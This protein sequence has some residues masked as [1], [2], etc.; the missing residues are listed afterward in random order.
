MLTHQTTPKLSGPRKFLPIAILLLAFALRVIAIDHIPPGLSHDEAYNGVTAMQVLDGQRLIFFEINKG[1]EPLIIYLEALAFYAFGIG[2][3]PMRLVN[4]MCGMLTVALIYPLTLRLFKRRV[5]LLAMAG[6]A[7][8]FWA[9]FTSRLALRAVTLPPL[10]M[11]SLYFLWRGISSQK[12]EASNQTS[13]HYSPFA[14]PHPSSPILYPLSSTF[15]SPSSLFFV[16]GGLALGATMYTYLSSRFVPLLVLAIFGYQFLRGQVTKWHWLGLIILLLIWAVIFAPLA[17]Y[18]WQHSA[19]F[20]E[21][22][23]QVSTLPYVLNGDVGP[24]QRHTLRTLGMFTFHGDETDRYNLDG[25]PVFDW[26][27]GLFFYLGLILALLRLRRPAYIA[28]PAALLLLWLFFMLLPGFITD[29]SPHFLRTVGAMPA[30]YILW[31]LGLDWAGQR[32]SRSLRL[33]PHASVRSLPLGRFRAKGPLVAFQSSIL[34]LLTPIFILLLLTGYDY[35]IRWA[36]APEARAIYGADIAEVARYV[37]ATPQEGLVAISAEY[38]RDLDPFRFTL[39][40]YGRPPFVIWFDG[41]QSLAFPPPE[42]GL[43]PRYIFPLSAPPAETWLPFLQS[44]PAQSGREYTLYR[45][46]KVAE[47]HQAQA[48]AFSTPHSLGVNINNDLMLSA[49]Q[50]LGSVVSGGKFRV[51]LGW[52][53]LRTLPPNADY[54]FLVQLQDKEDRVWA[55]ADGNGYPPSEWQ[56]GVQGLQLLV[57]RLPGDLP[58]RAYHLT[59]QV[60]DRHSGQALP[61]SMG[62]TVIPLGNLAGQLAKTPRLIDPAKLPN[63]I[64][65]ASAEGPGQEIALRGYEV[66]NSTAHPGESLAV[67]L[68][69]QVLQPPQNYHLEFSL[70]NDGKETVYRWPAVEPINGE[71]PT[72]Y[73]PAGYWVQDRLDL[74]LG[75]DA[76]V[77]QFILQGAWVSGASDSPQPANPGEIPGSFELGSVTIV[78]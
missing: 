8:S 75:E 38:Y 16:L 70:V 69:W 42:S 55:A 6:L 57:L 9:V 5:A 25:R 30:A 54:T 15:H 67:T 40:S 28:G 62:E 60:V 31:A 48:A 45:L 41:R 52:Q 22:S 77:G 43:S 33:T 50:V 26:L 18:F 37:N 76:P 66:K 11:L 61:T 36:N 13:A 3:V 21:R 78:D 46:R 12:S 72:Q 65:T 56:P 23:S 71:W 2:P 29:D 47:L 58:P 39:H 63:P 34:Y 49:Y 7:V 1:I 35:F 59:V 32:I 74:P 27:N 24:L 10:L 53:A 51:L 20:T 44:D 4:V 68:H 19:S 64:S 17:N 73:W 14:V